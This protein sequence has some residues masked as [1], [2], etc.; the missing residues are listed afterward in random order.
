M[1][2]GPEPGDGKGDL[3]IEAA[4]AG[5]VGPLR[6]TTYGAEFEAEVLRSRP[7][8]PTTHSIR[9]ARH[10]D[11]DFE[12]VQ[13]TFLSLRTDNADDWS[14][15]RTM[16]LASSPTR[17]H[18][19]Y[20]VRLSDSAWKRA[21]AALSPGD[22]VLVEGPRGHFVLREDRPAVLVAGGIG[23]TPLKGMAEYAT[24]RDLEIPVVL[25][26]SN[27]TSEEIAFRDPIDAL[28]RA[29]PRM[30]VVHTITRP[31]G[32]GDGGADWEGRTGRIDEEL[33]TEV[34]EDVEAAGAE[35]PV[36]YLCGTPGMVEDLHGLL[37]GMGV[38]DGDILY[39]EFWGY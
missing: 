14:D 21:F 31:D 33:L 25:L 24:D 22:R 29:N 16:S 19:E 38:P 8:T 35:D 17:D 27:R 12:P 26:Y 28:E 20:G 4:G 7:E 30:T 10:P 1:A 39:E 2:D 13:F 37:R 9:V 11:F 3:D 32:A 18:L 5:R 34:A 15:Y 6:T 23:I 36:Y